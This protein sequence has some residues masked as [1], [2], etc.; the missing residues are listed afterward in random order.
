VLLKSNLRLLAAQLERLAETPYFS[1]RLDT[2]IAELKS[3][4]TALI[5]RLDAS[6][7]AINVEIARFLADEIWR[8]TQ[9]L[10]GST[11]KQIPYEVVYAIERAASGWTSSQLLVTTAIVQESNFYFQ[12]SNEDF[13][14]V[15]DK[16]L[17]IYLAT[18][19]VQIALP[20]I[21]RHK[22]LFCVPLFHELGHFVD[23]VNEVVTTTMLTSPET[24]GPDLPDLPTCAQIAQ[25]SPNEIAILRNVVMSHRQEYFADLFSVAYVGDASKGFLQEFCPANSASPTHP[26]SEARFRLMAD[27]LNGVANPIVELFQ[28][29]LKARGLPAL[30][31]TFATVSLN[32][33][34]GNV[35][36]FTPTSDKELFGLFEAGWSFLMNQPK[37]SSY[38]VAGSVGGGI[39]RPI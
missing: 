3:V 37:N 28:G 10:T 17:G 18:R 14:R 36:P 19:P 1:P 16:E 25:L 30:A 27:F 31:P 24:V 35:R 20:Y 4:T 9:F 6:S 38:P 26:S 2:Y 11:T 21:Y 12:G 34:F 8:L 32:A 39:G 13:F 29:A 23:I 15:V 22:P 33:T 5:G 7:A